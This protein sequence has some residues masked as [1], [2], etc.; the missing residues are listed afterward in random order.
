MLQTGRQREK[1]EADEMGEIKRGNIDTGMQERN[2]NKG[3]DQITASLRTSK[4]PF[5]LT[6]NADIKIHTEI[7]R[8]HLLPLPRSDLLLETG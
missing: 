7:V 1:R 3:T 5:I 2:S 4:C 6:R 8:S